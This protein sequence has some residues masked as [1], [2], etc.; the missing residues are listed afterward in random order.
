M[1]QGQESSGDQ[2]TREVSDLVLVRLTRSPTGLFADEYRASSFDFSAVKLTG[3]PV[4]KA[5]RRFKKLSHSL[6]F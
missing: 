4:F 6:W 2:K 1:E 5:E 3:S